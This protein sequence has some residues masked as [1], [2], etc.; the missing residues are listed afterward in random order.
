MTKKT[1][2]ADAFDGELVRIIDSNHQMCG[3]VGEAAYDPGS[4]FY[5]VI[6]EEGGR[7]GRS[8]EYLHI[9]QLKVV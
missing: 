7:I 9:D 2:A 5:D 8:V 1:Q 6:E 4:G 3:F